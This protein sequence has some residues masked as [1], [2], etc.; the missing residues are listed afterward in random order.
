VGRR[1]LIYGANGYTGRLVTAEAVERGL[2]PILAGRDAHAVAELAADLGLPHRA[3]PLDETV[4]LELAL[5]ATGVV[6]HCAGPYSA[7]SQRMADA[8]LRTGA[9]YLDLTGELAVFEARLAQDAAARTAG[10][11]LLPGAGFDVVAT[12]C[13]AAG[14]AT[15]LPGATHLEL[16]LL[17]LGGVSRGTARSMLEAISLGGAEC[18]EGRIVR[19]PLG[20]RRDIDFGRGPVHCISLPWG[21]VCT[22]HVSTGIPNVIAHAAAPGWLRLATR[23][24]PLRTLLASGPMRA[25]ARRRIAA[26]PPGPDAEARARGRCL[27]WGEVRDATG[28]RVEA[29]LQTADGYTFTARAAVALARH[30]LAHEPPPGFQT[31]AR[32]MGSEFALG[33]EGT[34]KVDW[35]SRE[36]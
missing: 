36:G 18:R 10:V 32:L 8:C 17:A 9:H 22:A 4:A 34:I 33:I 23:Y 27:V 11:M 29:R 28:R 21:D 7:T 13:L 14:L 6:L 15:R 35:R 1:L 16:G 19:V 25:I 20:A 31:P 5:E 24:A 2:E 26:M 3:F 30:V 12:D